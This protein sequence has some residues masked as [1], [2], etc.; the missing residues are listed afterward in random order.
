MFD[1]SKK[2][3]TEAG[4]SYTQHLIFALSVV[5]KMLKAGIQCFLHALI[6]SI[7]KSSGS[8]AIKE[9]YNKINTRD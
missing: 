2:H 1:D 7:F 9:L 3:L 8:N 4:E 5:L 6:P